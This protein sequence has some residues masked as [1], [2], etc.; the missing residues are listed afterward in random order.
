E[1]LLG[2]QQE[3]DPEAALKEVV[4]KSPFVYL[5]ASIASLSRKLRVTPADV[6]TLKQLSA[7]GGFGQVPVIK[8]EDLIAEEQKEDDDEQK[9]ED[10]EHVVPVDDEGTSIRICWLFVCLLFLGGP[11]ADPTAFANA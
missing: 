2:V 1:N 9:E 4:G 3:P 6:E 11:A 5:E 7:Q 10:P 8:L